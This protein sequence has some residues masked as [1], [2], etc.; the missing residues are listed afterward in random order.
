[1]KKINNYSVQY[2]VIQS[3]KNNPNPRSFANKNL[4]GF[5]HKKYHQK[6][7]KNLLIT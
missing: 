2:K 3:H 7:G 5:S 6:I 4:E 1:M